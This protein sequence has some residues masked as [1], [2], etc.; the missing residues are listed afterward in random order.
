MGFSVEEVMTT[1]VS[2]F[3][4]QVDSNALTSCLNYEQTFVSGFVHGD[5]HP[6]KDFDL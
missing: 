6:G 4:Y 3:A 5:P 2:A 1:F